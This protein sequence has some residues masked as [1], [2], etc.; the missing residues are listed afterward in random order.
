[1]KSVKYF[2]TT[3]FTFLLCLYLYSYKGAQK[4]GKNQVLDKIVHVDTLSAIIDEYRSKNFPE[5][6]NEDT[7]FFLVAFYKESG[8]NFLFLNGNRV[9]IPSVVYAPPRPNTNEQKR[10]DDE[11]FL[12]YGRYN[13]NYIFFYCPK[14]SV[15]VKHY[16]ECYELKKDIDSDLNLKKYHTNNA[17]IDAAT[18]DFHID[19]DFG[20]KRVR[21]NQR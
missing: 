16:T 17:F 7:L 8:E 9:E 19:K 13:N 2:I 10:N 6:D 14:D 12:G 11:L 3:T 18:W 5:K 21:K 20:L 15:I 4:G 1:M